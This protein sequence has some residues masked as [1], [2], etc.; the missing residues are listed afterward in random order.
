MN[1]GDNMYKINELAILAGISSRTLR[2]YDDIDLLSPKRD[3]DSMYRLYTEEDIDTLQT[4]MFYKELGYEL[5][6]IKE[7]I[8]NKDF[9]IVSSLEEMETK[10]KKK[11]SSYELILLTIKQTLQSK[12]GDTN[13]SNMKKFEAFKDDKLMIN[14][15]KYREE[16]NKNYDKEFVK[17]SNKK[18]KNKTEQEMK[19]HEEFTQEMHYIM[20]EAIN[21]DD[22]T[23]EVSMKMCDMHKQ[24]LMF[25]WPTYTKSQHLALTEMYTQDERFSKHYND[26]HPGLA[27]FLYEAMKIYMAK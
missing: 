26:L 1:V 13:M 22:P 20:F 3:E 15:D 6:E 9:D 2:H 4:I 24:W 19:N 23:N 18:Y 5:K 27:L 7:V 8:S 11:M 14:N 12:K 17:R 16:M 21:L 10:L 25:Y